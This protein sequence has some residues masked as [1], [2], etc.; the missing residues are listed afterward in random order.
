MTTRAKGKT[1]TAP[2]FKTGRAYSCRSICDYDCIFSFV[3]TKRTAQTVWLRDSSGKVRARRI[4]RWTDGTEWCEPHGQYSMSPALNA[5]NA[6]C[7]T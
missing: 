5:F 3:V 7:A 6:E 4:K 2:T 1:M